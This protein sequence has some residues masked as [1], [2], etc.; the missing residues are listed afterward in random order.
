MVG[1]AVS[2]A[3]LMSLFADPDAAPER[4]EFK[5][6]VGSSTYRVIAEGNRVTV[7]NKAFL[8]GRTMDD[9]DRRRMAVKQV[10]GC[11]V[12]DEMWFDAKMVGTLTCSAK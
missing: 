2:I 3:L 1:E 10:T 6:K 8:T 7:L 4:R 12:T 11:D 9:R 5:A